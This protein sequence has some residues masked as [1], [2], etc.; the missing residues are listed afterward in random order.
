LDVAQQ[1]LRV[2]KSYEIKHV[3]A[4][5][6]RKHLV[7]F[8]LVDKKETGPQMPA[9]NVDPAAATPAVTPISDNGKTDL[10]D[11]QK[12]QVSVLTANNSLLINATQLQHV[13]IAHVIDYVDATPRQE[14]IPYEIYFLENQD[15][16]HMAEVLHQLLQESVEDKD[17]KI[18]KVVHKIDEEIV[19]V[20]DENTFSLIVY[21]SRKN[22]EWVRKLIKTLDKR[23]PQVLIDATLVEI[24]KNDEFNYD[25]EMIAG[26]PDL[27]PSSGQVPQF[28]ADENTTVTDKLESSGRSNFAEF[29]V[30]SGKGIGFYADEHIQALLTAVRTKNYGRV[31]AKPK[32]LVND[33]EKGNIKTADTTYVIKKSSVP[34]V[35]GTAGPQSNTIET[36]I[37]YEPY[38]AGITLEI[39]PHIS[40]GDLLRLDV[41]LSRSDFT[42]VSADKPPNQTSSNVGTVVTVPD[43][44]TIILGGML[45]LNQ[46]KGGSKIPILGDLPLIGGVFRSVNTSDVQSMLYIFVRAQVIRPADTT[47][48]SQEDL[49]R[50]SDANREAFEKHE[51]EFQAH[52]TWPG[53]KPKPVSPPK[54]LDAR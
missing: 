14:S 17:A 40:D 19:I 5:E 13:R 43:G 42:S 4:E 10:A 49:T 51:Q 1:D 15:P 3:D 48:N 50:I 26:L 29:Q 16:V 31:L 52:Q 8:D 23:R 38:E 12:P 28:K 54:V 44:S 46:N 37:N 47:S 6:V 22:Q 35:S 18:E 2:F 7:E 25:L 36:A 41:Q 11:P 9:L 45:K 34:V 39:T 53:V 20:P 33:N 24:R 21:A 32:V 27:S 30:K